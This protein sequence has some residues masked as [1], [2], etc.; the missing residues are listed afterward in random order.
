MDKSIHT[1]EYSEF[2]KKLKQ[3]RLDA[4]LTQVQA[5][6]KLKCSQSYISKLEARELRMD[7]VELQ[8]FARLYGKNISFFMQKK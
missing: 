4:G 2:A 8:R 1:K 6:K 3:A 7:I 5:A